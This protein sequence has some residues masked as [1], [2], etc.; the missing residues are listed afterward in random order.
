MNKRK[1]RSPISTTAGF[2]VINQTNEVYFA[3]TVRTHAETHKTGTTKEE[4]IRDIT[5]II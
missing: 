4:N 2:L 1:V 3:K 5:K